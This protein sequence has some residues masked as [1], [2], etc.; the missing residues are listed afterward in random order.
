LFDLIR[1][2]PSPS[3]T[4]DILRNGHGQLAEHWDVLQDEAT[5]A[6]SVNGLPKSDN[7]CPG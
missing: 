1:A 2:R 5:I 4:V 6:N 3:I 7:R